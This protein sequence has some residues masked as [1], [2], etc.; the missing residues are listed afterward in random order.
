M[1]RTRAPRPIVRLIRFTEL[2][3][4]QCA[5]GD[6]RLA[7]RLVCDAIANGS[8]RRTGRRGPGG[9][10]L[11]RFEGRPGPAAGGAPVAVLGELAAP[12]CVAL[13]ILR[14]LP[15]AGIWAGPGFLNRSHSK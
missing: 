14:P 13:R 7:E 2:V 3:A 15:A 8:R 4:R 12:A 1:A 9:G 5:L 6:A 11:V 10:P